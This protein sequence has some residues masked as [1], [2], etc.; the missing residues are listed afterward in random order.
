M[1]M[2][3]LTATYAKTNFGLL[4]QTVLTEPVCIEKNGRELA[5]VI[6]SQEYHRLR[7]AVQLS[8]PEFDGFLAALD[9]PPKPN[10][11]LKRAAKRYAKLVDPA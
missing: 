7:E 3:A 11:A 6:S 8:R 9:A 1:A 2:H 4:M 10:A 5:Y